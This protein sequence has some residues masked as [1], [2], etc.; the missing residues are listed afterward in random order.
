MA[1][2]AFSYSLSPSFVVRQFLLFAQ[3][4][5]G[6]C[7]LSEIA[8]ARAAPRDRRGVVR[9]T[10]AHT[11]YSPGVAP[12]ITGHSGVLQ[13]VHKAGRQGHETAA[14]IGVLDPRKLW[15][16]HTQVPPCPLANLLGLWAACGG[17]PSCA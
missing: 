10:C 17:A 5:S 1:H 11:E 7:L 9:G 3:S 6:A 4:K 13:P 14:H 12:S 15:P 16:H 8:S 2:C